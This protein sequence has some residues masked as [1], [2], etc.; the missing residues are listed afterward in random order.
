M[1][2][3]PILDEL[4]TAVRGKGAFLNGEPLRVSPC[5]D[6]GSA[7]IISEIGVARDDATIAA[8]FGRMSA[9]IK[10]VRAVL[11]QLGLALVLTACSN[12]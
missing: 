11:P 7:M 1:V 12:V 8:L 9:L 2:Y 10:Q 4:Y 6:L 5:K 3:N